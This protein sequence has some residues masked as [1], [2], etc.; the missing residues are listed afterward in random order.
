MPGQM[1]AQARSMSVACSRRSSPVEAPVQQA[2]QVGRRFVRAQC[3]RVGGPP[4]QELALLG[5]CQQQPTV[6]GMFEVG[7]RPRVGSPNR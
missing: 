3:F 4:V 6:E 7:C 2:E 1:V 5:C